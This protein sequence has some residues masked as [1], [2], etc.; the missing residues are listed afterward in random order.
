V[1]WLLDEM[2]PPET[3]GHLNALGHDAVSVY[4]VGLTNVR[5]GQILDVGVRERR[6][7]VTEN[8]RDFAVL[9]HGR[10]SRGEPCVP[11][12]FV[13]RDALPRRGA[14]PVHLAR[15][16]D[17]WAKANPDPYVSPHWL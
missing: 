16:L 9:L 2:L 11:V 4:H 15:L 6:I 7:V 8:H 14:L 12:A 13:R 3:C 1:R 10:L 17:G 5:D